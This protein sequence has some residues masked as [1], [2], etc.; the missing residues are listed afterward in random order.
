M[1]QQYAVRRDLWPWHRAAHTLRT[2]GLYVCPHGHRRQE[3]SILVK[4]S[5]KT[6]KGKGMGAGDCDD[7]PER[8]W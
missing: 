1:L 4:V 8:G 6:Y 7:T 3:V 2:K 5:K